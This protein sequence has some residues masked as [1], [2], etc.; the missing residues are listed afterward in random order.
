MILTVIYAFAHYQVGDKI[1]DPAMIEEV[2]ASEN[3]PK[4]VRV[5]VPKA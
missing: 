1:T 5:D 4:V 3:S 2:L